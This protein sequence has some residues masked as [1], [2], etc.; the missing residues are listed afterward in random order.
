MGGRLGR[1]V[2][3]ERLRLKLGQMGRYVAPFWLVLPLAFLVVFFAYP[4]A[5]V[6]SE[7]TM[8][9]WAWMRT[10][11]VVGRLQGA[12]GQALLS[13]ALGMALAMPLAWVYHRYQLRFGRWQLALHAAP[14]IMPVFVVVFGLQ[15]LFAGLGISLSPL[16]TVVVAH[17][18]YNYGFA[19][20]ILRTGLDRRPRRQEA[21]AR[22]LGA[23][24]AAAFWRVSL[25]HLW[26]TFGAVALLVFLFSF[27]SFGVVLFMGQGQ[28]STLETMLYQNL[29]GAF[30]RYDRAAALGTAQLVLNLVL[31]AS[32]LRLSERTGGLEQDPVARR[33]RAPRLV[34]AAQGAASLVAAAPMLLVLAGGFRLNGHWSL[35]PW[36]ALVDVGHPV[37]VAGFVLSRALMLSLGYAA[38]TVVA[39]IAL[40]LTLAYASRRL[41]NWARRGLDT[42]TSL[43]LGTSSLLIGLGFLLAFGAGDWLDLRGKT[44]AIIAAHTLIAFPFAARALLPAIRLHDARLDEAAALLGAPPWHVLWRV[45]LPLLAAPLTVAAGLSAAMSLGDFGASLV[46]MRPDNM[47]LTV[48]IGRIDAPFD[49]LRKAQALALTGLLTVLAIIVIAAGERAQLGAPAREA[50]AR[51]APPRRPM[52]AMP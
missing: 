50:S 11:Y 26:P 35:E 48:W 30:P 16:W 3:G 38:A 14:F 49:S 12:V 27:T 28:I 47:G 33:Q 20:R 51:E 19:A 9:A 23:T 8:A 46:L 37:H 29:G 13:T 41:P 45:H 25:P 6:L 24:P 34:V 1:T 52:E 21:A 42:T 10:P 22:A 15:R 44:I 40:A 17:A 36:R 43:P 7:A 39:A 5:G 18:Y 31:F 4:L 2:R 32:Y